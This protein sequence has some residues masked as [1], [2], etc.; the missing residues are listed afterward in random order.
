MRARLLKS[1]AVRLAC[2]RLLGVYLHL[3]LRSTRWAVEG[4]EHLAPF[5]AGG[6]VIVACWHERLPLMP[7]LLARALA[8][9]P[10]REVCALASRHRDGRLI[11]AILAR[12]GVRSVFGSTGRSRP[13]RDPARDNGGAAGLRGLV[14]A[15]E[16]GQAVVVTPDGPRGPRRHAAPGVAGLAALT[17]A[18]VLVTAAQARRRIVLR[19]WDRMVVPLPFGRGALVCLPPVAVAR[20]G[21]Q[22]AQAGLGA[23]LDRAADRA[24]A[25]CR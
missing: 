8:A 1:E 22:A 20:D 4:G 18:P 12:F 19:S 9:N 14:A 10:G 6:A 5:L 16:A 11:A 13:G 7:A 15:L 21:A 24:D 17:G 3:T 25:L 2:A 23:A